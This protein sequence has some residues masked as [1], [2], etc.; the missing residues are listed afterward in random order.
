MDI[1][2]RHQQKNGLCTLCHPN[3]KLLLSM[4]VFPA[5]KSKTAAAAKERKLGWNVACSFKNQ[6]NYTYNNTGGDC[7]I[8]IEPRISSHLIQS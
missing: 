7:Q 3:Q 6:S 5:R 8:G 4:N 1:T 2:I